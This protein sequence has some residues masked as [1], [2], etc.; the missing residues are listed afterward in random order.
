ML[1][2]PTSP[3]AGMPVP[4]HGEFA[5]AK[6]QLA[7]QKIQRCAPGLTQVEQTIPRLIQ[8]G[9]AKSEWLTLQTDVKNRRQGAE[10]VSRI[11]G[12]PVI[13]RLQ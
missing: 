10:Y 8:Q 7:F 4:G 11:G 5:P 2:A 13:C 1:I 9:P 12:N 6:S 3:S